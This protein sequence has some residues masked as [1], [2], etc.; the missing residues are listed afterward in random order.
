M[1]NGDKYQRQ[2]LSGKGMYEELQAAGG[3]FRWK[4]ADAA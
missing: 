2:N 3:K 1:L 4:W